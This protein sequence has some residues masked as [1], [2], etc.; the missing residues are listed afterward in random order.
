MT[1]LSKLEKY[2]KE[3]AELTEDPIHKRL[4]TA[5]TGDNPKA[6]MEAELSRILDEVMKHED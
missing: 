3:L 2:S 5:Y 4:I 6:S 1:D